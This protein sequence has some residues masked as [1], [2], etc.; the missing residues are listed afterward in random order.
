MNAEINAETRKNIKSTI[1]LL[2]RKGDYAAPIL[3]EK[4]SR[5]FAIDE[6]EV[7]KVIWQMTADEII[8]FSN[9]FKTLS[10]I[11]DKNK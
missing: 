5:A 2:L 9:G 1:L 4:V 6:L 10:L 11:I 7:R 3:I 8:E